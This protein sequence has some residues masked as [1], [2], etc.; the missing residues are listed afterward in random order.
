MDV[1]AKLARPPSLT[2]LH[3][4]HPSSHPGEGNRGMHPSVASEGRAQAPVDQD[5]DVVL[6]D[7]R[8][9]VAT[10]PSQPS[11]AGMPESLLEKKRKRAM[12]EPL[13]AP[14]SAGLPDETEELRTNGSG[15]SARF[16]IDAKMNKR[17]KVP[18]KEYLGRNRGPRTGPGA[19]GRFPLDHSRLP[20]NIW[21]EIFLAC[22]PVSLARLTR[23]NKLFHKFLTEPTGNDTAAG[24][25]PPSDE[26]LEGVSPE[27]IWAA[28]RQLYFPDMPEPLEGFTEAEMWRL[29]AGRRCQFCGR[30]GDVTGDIYG[31]G[32]MGSKT[33]EDDLM[34]VWAFAA[35]SC[36]PCLKENSEKVCLTDPFELHDRSRAG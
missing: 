32:L 12:E 3:Q 4:I 14:P 16:G 21:H 28:S 19:G 17:L 18:F 5:G 9:A 15:G 22:T 1:D 8:A 13:S 35:R 26:P 30:Y 25:G 11:G 7:A 34:V 29:L 31:Q 36:A 6:P 27:R 10:E 2:A 33:G 20:A 24:P 23:V